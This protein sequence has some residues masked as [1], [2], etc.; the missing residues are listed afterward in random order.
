MPITAT[1]VSSNRSLAATIG[2]NAIFGI[3]S[4]AAQIGT[5][6]I[7][8]PVVIGH[9][10]LGGYGIW[11]IIMVTAAY[12]RFGCA[13]LKSAFQKYVAEA[14]GNGDFKTASVLLSTG[15]ISMLALSVIGLIPLALFS[16]KLAAASGVPHQF[17]G[18]ATASI[19]VLAAIYVISN[20]GAAFEAIVTGGHRIDLTRKYATLLTVLE[21]VVI[22]LMLGRG[23]GLLAMS[24]IMGI[25]ELIYIL[26][27]FFASRRVVPQIKIGMAYFSKS[28]YPELIRFAGSYQLV[29]IL[30]LLY[31]SILPIVLLKL[32]GAVAAGV[33][34]VASRVVGSALI[35]Q[36]ALVLPIL[37]GG[38][39]VFTSGPTERIRLFLAKS[40]KVTLA[41]TLPPLA[42]V[43]AFGTAL[44]YAWTGESNPMFRMAI[45]L[46]ALAAL[47]KA[48][49]L[50]QLILY[51]ASGKAVLDNVRQALKIVVI[52]LVA[53]FGRR[54]GFAGVLVGMAGAELLGVI[55]MFVAMA[56]AFH[57]FSAKVFTIDALRILA[58]TG[59]IVAAGA[60]V[61][62]IPIPWAVPERLAAAAKLAEIALGCFLAAW[63]A[64]IMTQS[65]SSSERRSILDSLIS[66]RRAALAADE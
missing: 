15:S 52:L 45:C 44:V 57:A 18:A 53:Y 7:T 12:M 33:F 54:L 64:L 39:V 34:A 66:R 27:C 11:S 10:G 31:A 3:L 56:S 55:F 58:A 47:L 59:I 28:A 63:P 14:T 17:M 6:L 40:F 25:S 32:F 36:E 50:I 46:T 9:L 1:S 22:I 8:V 60:M 13:G 49:S 30:E 35:A 20:A 37:S 2:K 24:L 41:A 62:M 48:I 4:N 19:S 16:H 65:V 5:R 42:C 26:C 21:A 43:A 51:R 29:N 38:T 23:Y 61:G